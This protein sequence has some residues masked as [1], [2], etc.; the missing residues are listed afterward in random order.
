MK[1]FLLKLLMG[2]S[3]TTSLFIFQACYGTPTEVYDIP[4]NKTQFEIAG[5]ESFL[6]APEAAQ[7]ESQQES[8]EDPEAEEEANL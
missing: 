7:Q 5:Q 4:R 6:E 3:L 1:K 2:A 8:Q